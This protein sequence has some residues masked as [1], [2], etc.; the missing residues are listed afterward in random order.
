MV[1]TEALDAAILAYQADPT[2]EKRE[3]VMAAGRARVAAF[4][5]EQAEEFIAR[6]TTPRRPV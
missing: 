6:T 2:P 1:S 3:V 5:A 4:H